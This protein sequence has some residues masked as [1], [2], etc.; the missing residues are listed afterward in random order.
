MSRCETCTRHGIGIG[1]GCYGSTAK[2][3]ATPLAFPPPPP[4]V[5]P[6]IQGS[7]VAAQAHTYAARSRAG[8]VS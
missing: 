2:Q 7:F 4:P 5:S 1:I 3:L 6:C 8:A